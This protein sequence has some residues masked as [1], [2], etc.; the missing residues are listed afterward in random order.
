MGRD[1]VG[2][3][4]LA[5]RGFLCRSAHTKVKSWVANVQGVDFGDLIHFY[6]I[7]R[8]LTPLGAFEIVRR[9]DFQ[10]TKG[11]PTGDDFTGPVPGCALYEV[12]E[13][14]FIQKLDPDGGYKPDPVLR[15]YTGW[16]LRKSG[17]AAPA[18]TK[19]LSETP[20]LVRR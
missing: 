14:S 4:L 12:A 3:L 16:L 17:A 20:T 11:Q 7:G 1:Y 13:P 9:E 6:F 10:N 8:K 2:T 5:N 19:F 15:T 18:P